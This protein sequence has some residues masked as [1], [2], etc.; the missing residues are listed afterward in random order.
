MRTLIT[1]FAIIA[2]PAFAGGGP[3]APK[4]IE[5]VVLLDKDTFAPSTTSAAPRSYSN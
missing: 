3:P 4:K 5:P 1:L 2:T